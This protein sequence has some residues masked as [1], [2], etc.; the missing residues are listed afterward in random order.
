MKNIT[1]EPSGRC[2]KRTYIFL[3]PLL[4]RTHFLCRDFN[5]FLLNVKTKHK[6]QDKNSVTAI[7]KGYE[8]FHNELLIIHSNPTCLYYIFVCVDKRKY[9]RLSDLFQQKNSKFVL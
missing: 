8:R 5:G 2:V 1:I 9:L 3:K 4:L 6:A 7:K